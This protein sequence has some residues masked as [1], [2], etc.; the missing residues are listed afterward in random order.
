[1]SVCPVDAQGYGIGRYDILF[2]TNVLHATRNMGTT[3]QHCKSLLRNGGLFI[4][5]ELS[6]KTVFLTLTFGLTDGWWL[7][8]DE[9]R[10]IPGKH[11]EPFSSSPTEY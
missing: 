6:A 5:N 11:T 10:R 1:M 3:I 9:Q 4:A 7:Y 2:A 8:D